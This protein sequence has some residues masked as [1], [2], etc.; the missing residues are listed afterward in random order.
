MPRTL[1][2]HILLPDPV[3]MA[4]LAVAFWPLVFL[5]DLPRT[6]CHVFCL[7]D[8]LDFELRAIL[9]KEEDGGEADGGSNMS[10][11]SEAEPG[12]KGESMSMSI[13]EPP[14]LLCD[15]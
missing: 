7:S 5:S 6:F 8:F 9:G 3:L 11:R 4:F 1:P 12:L 2:F 13:G 14:E 10:E 15:I